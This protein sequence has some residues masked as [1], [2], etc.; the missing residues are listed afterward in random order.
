MKMEAWLDSGPMIDKQIFKLSFTD[1]VAELIQ[2]VKEFT[3]K[4]SL[5]SIDSYVHGEL[6][7][8]IQDESKVTHCGKIEKEDGFIELSV[9][10]EKWK[11]DSLETIYRKY[12]WYY[13]WPK[14]YTELQTKSG[15]LR[16]VIE[17]L[18]L[19]EILFAQYK[20]NGLLTKNFELNPAII[21]L[22]VKP[23]GKKAM[24]WEDFR[25]G[26]L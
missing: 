16:L 15:E 17:E 9:D 20:D 2:R 13:L 18:V 10:N 8:E 4:R 22:K 5:D 11:G 6:Q 19:D 12:K 1:T 21:S 14:L 25:R 3:P 7:E 26:Y 23:E 24:S